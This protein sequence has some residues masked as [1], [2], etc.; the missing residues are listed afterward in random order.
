MRLAPIPASSPP[1]PS[2]KARPRRSTL[3]PWTTCGP[4]S[5]WGRRWSLRT[6]PRSSTRSRSGTPRRTARTPTSSGRP[7]GRRAARGASPPTRP[8]TPPWP[9]SPDGR[10][11]AFVSKRDGD[12]VA[13]LY[14]LSLWGGEAERVT[15][16]PSAVSNPKW[17]RRR[18]AHRLRLLRARGCGGARGAR[19]RALEAREK[20]NGE[21]PRQR[22]PP[23]PLLGPLAHRRR[24]PA[25]LRASISRPA[26]SRDLLPGS[27][28]ATSTCQ[29]GTAAPST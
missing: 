5:A 1:P 11:I 9:V 17:L 12:A 23:L 14:V 25:H 21:G 2:R 24:V 15:D 8:P 10:R 28:A 18:Q 7:G 6:E 3:S 26:R 4:S 22:Q 19:R 20:S 29:E 13:Q 16:R 27:T